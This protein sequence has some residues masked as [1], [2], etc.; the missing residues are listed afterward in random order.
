MTAQCCHGNRKRGLFVSQKMHAR[1]WWTRRVS[2][3]VR[4]CQRHGWVLAPEYGVKQPDRRWHA[5]R[6]GNQNLLLTYSLAAIMSCGRLSHT[7]NLRPTQSNSLAGPAG[8]CDAGQT[9]KQPQYSSCC[10]IKSQ[11]GEWQPGGN[12]VQ[13]TCGNC[14]PR[15]QVPAPGQSMNWGW[16]G[17]RLTEGRNLTDR[18]K[19]GIKNCCDSEL[20]LAN[21]VRT[22]CLSVCSRE[23]GR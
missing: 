3:G 13:L 11:M 2:P 20:Q 14:H 4:S 19:I 9:P 21:L 22:E 10:Q 16:V 5:G 23:A 17:E 12:G 18:Y 6:T 8:V 15:R 1:R 7:P